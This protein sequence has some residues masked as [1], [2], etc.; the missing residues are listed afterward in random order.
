ME[1]SH[2]FSHLPRRFRTFETLV[3]SVKKVKAE[4]DDALIYHGC[5]VLP[6]FGEKMTRH[7]T[8]K[9]KT[10]QPMPPEVELA[11][12]GVPDKNWKKKREGNEGLVS[13]SHDVPFVP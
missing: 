9:I 7:R 5:L 1:I 4:K 3:L 11:T 13:R 6:A 8:R 12:G 2:L 10:R